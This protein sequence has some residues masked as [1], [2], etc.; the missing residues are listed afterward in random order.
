M[1]VIASA[2]LSVPAL[3]LSSNRLPIK[4]KDHARM[5]IYAGDKPPVVAYSWWVRRENKERDW[6]AFWASLRRRRGRKSL[7]LLERDGD[8]VRLGYAG[9]GP[10]E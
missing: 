10:S 3:A 9:W 6:D 1:L 2:T 7:S 4:A 8:W 5:G